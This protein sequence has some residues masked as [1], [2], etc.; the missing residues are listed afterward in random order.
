[1]R[2]ELCAREGEDVSQF[3][4]HHLEPASKRKT[5][6][7]ITVCRQCGD[8]IHNLFQ[9]FELK[10]RFNTLEKLLADERI[11]KWLAWVGKQPLGHHVGMAKKKRRR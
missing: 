9:N 11:Q 8:Q 5:S 10:T 6:E 1:M 4:A 2:C 3:E 7:T